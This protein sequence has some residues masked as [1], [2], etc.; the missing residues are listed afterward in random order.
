MEHLWAPWR[1]SYIEGD[2]GGECVFCPRGTAQEMAARLI[3]YRGDAALVMMNKYPYNN[4]H[5]LVAPARHISDIVE[6]SCE[7]LFALSVTVK[8]SVLILKKVMNPAGFNLGM[9]VGACAG[10]GITSHLHYHVVPRWQGDTN[11]MPVL[12]EIKVVPEHLEDT[13][14]KLV[15]HFQELDGKLRAVR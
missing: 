14:R 6:L 9:N 8:E 10:A 5:L 11:F 13:Y 2:V 4:G 12:A 7:E 15:P 3:L 1:M